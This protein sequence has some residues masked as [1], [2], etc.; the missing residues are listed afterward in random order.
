MK[1]RL[2]ALG[3]LLVLAASCTDDKPNRRWSTAITG[4]SKPA[5]TLRNLP[6]NSSTI[7][8]ATVRKRDQLLAKKP[9]ANHASLDAT[10]DDVCQ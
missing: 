6:A 2:V 4:P 1:S 5:L 3:G 7:C 9:T 10:I 8:V